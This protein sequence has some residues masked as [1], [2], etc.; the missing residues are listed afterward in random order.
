M[1][2]GAV[3]VDAAEEAAVDVT[4]LEVEGAAV[5]A[6]LNGQATETETEPEGAALGRSNTAR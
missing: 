2:A 5:T 4:V 3:L 1:T 6:E